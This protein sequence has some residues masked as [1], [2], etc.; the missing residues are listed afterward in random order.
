MNTEEYE[1][2]VADVLRAEGWTTTVT[3]LARDLGVDVLATREGRRLAVQA[4]MYGSSVTKVNAEQIMCLHGASAYAGCNESMLVTDGQLTHKAELVA[5][6]LGIA[7]K[8]IAVPA[9]RFV[10]NL[11]PG[12]RSFGAIWRDHIEPLAGTELVRESGKTM[13]IV[14]VDGSG[15]RRLTTG[16]R[17]QRISIDIFRWTIDRL[18]A[19]ETVSR[20]EIHERNPRKVSSG[21]MLILGSVPGF[22]TVSIGRG[23]ALRSRST[24]T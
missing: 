5:D 8:R 17:A 21:V 4:K 19:G 13:K 22:E 15:I 6:K 12:T 23:K 11:R 9:V 7:V 2:H 10:E 14:E 24:A 1:H 20:Q 16:G 18:L 3:R